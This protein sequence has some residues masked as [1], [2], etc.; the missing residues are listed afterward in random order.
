MRAGLPASASVDSA[1][2]FG[3]FAG[4]CLFRLRGLGKH[5]RRRNRDQH[6]PAPEQHPHR[7]GAQP[8]R[9]EGA[10]EV[11]AAKEQALAFMKTDAEN[12]VDD[13]RLRC[14]DDAGKSFLAGTF[15]AVVK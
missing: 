11:N 7:D 6:D 14:F 4:S 1:P 12:A 9:V 3:Y 10:L 15:E 8:D 5:P 13:F 2:R